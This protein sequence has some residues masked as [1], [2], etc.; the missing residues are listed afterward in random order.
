L[1]AGTRW[2][3]SSISFPLASSQQNLP[4]IYLMYVQS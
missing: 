1:L 4:D 2:N 3:G